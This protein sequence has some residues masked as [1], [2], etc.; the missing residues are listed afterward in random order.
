M[1]F[2]LFLIISL[3]QAA[4]DSDTPKELPMMNYKDNYRT[5]DCWECFA[6]KGKMCHDK[7]NLSMI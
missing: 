3:T 6:A 5:F 4:Y 1:A 2:F 7:D